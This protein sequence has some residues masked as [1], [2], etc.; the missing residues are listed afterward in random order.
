M[1]LFAFDRARGRCRLE[2]V[3]PGRLDKDAELLAKPYT[4]ETLAIKVRSVLDAR[5]N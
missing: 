1:T 4:R 3:H 5:E 2:S